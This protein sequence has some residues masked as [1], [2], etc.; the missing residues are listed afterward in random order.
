MKSKEFK[1]LEITGKVVSLKSVGVQGDYRT[2][3]HPV[4]LKCKNL[5]K[6]NWDFLGELST[7]ITNNFNEVNRVIVLLL[8]NNGTDLDLEAFGLISNYFITDNR[9]NI[10]KEADDIANYKL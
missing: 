6:F 10:L 8:D 9:L 4:V 3:S 7:K 1:V 2:Y 5:V